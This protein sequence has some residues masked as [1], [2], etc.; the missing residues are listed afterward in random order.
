MEQSVQKQRVAIYCRVANDSGDHSVSR[1]DQEIHCTGIVGKYPE[2]ELTGIYS[3]MG[4]TSAD[5]QK[6]PQFKKMLTDC[7][8]GKI[9]IILVK[10]VSRFARNIMDCL[11]TVG[12]LKAIGVGV[13]F[14]KEGIDTRT[15]SGEL[16]TTVYCKLAQRE[17][18]ALAQ[19]P[20][21]PMI[22]PCR[23]GCVHMA[24]GKG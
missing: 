13:I 4:V 18:E 23:Y 2:W 9:D 1:A 11:E 22:F 5:R 21:Y 8:Q 15:E 3:D 12:M 6:Q 19:S 10:S 14:E 17:I 16:C 7:R 24:G 20:G